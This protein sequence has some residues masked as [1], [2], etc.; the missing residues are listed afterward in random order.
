MSKPQVSDLADGVVTDVQCWEKAR[1]GHAAEERKSMEPP[2][3]ERNVG[4]SQ[5]ETTFTAFT[6]F[7]KMQA[8]MHINGP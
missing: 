1:L 3:F 7:L 8:P 2:F 6:I 4:L 5:S